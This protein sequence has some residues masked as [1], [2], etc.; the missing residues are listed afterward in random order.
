VKRVILCRPEGPRNV[1]TVLRVVQNFGPA[2]LW[3]VRPQRASMLVHPDFEQ[4]SHGAD[5]ARAAIVVVDSLTEALADCHRSVA[6]TARVRGKRKRRDWRQVV[7]EVR[8]LGDSAEQRLALVFGNEV[9]GLT[10][11][12]VDLCQDLVHVRT[13]NEHTSLNLA[14]GV[15]IALSDLFSGDT[16]HQK[17]PGGSLLDGR[18]RE[19][20]KARLQEVF[21]GQV[22]R[23]PAA[24]GDIEAM[25]ERVFSRAPL[26]NRDARAWHLILKTLGSSLDPTE[27]GLTLHEKDGR[28]RKMQERRAARDGDE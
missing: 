5:D 9:A 20:L 7:G 23:T 10:S 17:E 12:E 14:M 21:A 4:M 16:V 3:L 22:A 28:R 11:E 26:E 18:G 24:A 13:S 27:L 19:F 1:G 2:E 25:I 6:F 15:G 8:A